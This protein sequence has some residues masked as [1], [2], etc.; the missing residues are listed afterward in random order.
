V[1]TNIRRK[2][3]NMQYEKLIGGLLVIGGV[4]LLH[5]TTGAVLAI[6]FGLIQFMPCA[7]K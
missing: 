7:R 2:G 1:L 5:P 3:Q 4:Y 6:V